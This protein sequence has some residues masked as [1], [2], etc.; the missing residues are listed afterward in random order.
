VS[1]VLAAAAGHDFAALLATLVAVIVG[2]KALGE[3]AQR[4]N[5]PAVLGE[6]VAGALLGASVLGVLDPSD[7]VIAAFPELGVIVLLFEIGL[8]T[9][10]RALARVGSAAAT[11]GLVGVAVPFA[12]GYG[13][14]SWLGMEPVSALVCGAALTATSIGIS[15]RV[16][17]DLGCLASREGQVVLGAA[18]LDDIVG[19]IILSVIAGVV[20]GTPV[21]ALGIGRTTGVAIG[22]VLVAIVLG[23]VT[24]PPLF[25]AVDRVRTWVRSD[26]SRSPSPSPSP[27]S[28]TSPARR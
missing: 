14:A 15:A 11:V 28:P 6:L 26:W 27:T 17:S 23:S 9:D 8:H 7:P 3:V 13:V 19:L 18:V 12:F 25:R 21:T 1:L 4:A 10:L 24:I 16:L 2:T 22:F 20:G 5:Q